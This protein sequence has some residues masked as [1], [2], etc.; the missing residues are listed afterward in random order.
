M[1]WKALE[2]DEFTVPQEVRLTPPDFV[3]DVVSALRDAGTSARKRGRVVVVDD[4]AELERRLEL[5][6]FLRAWAVA[7]PG[8]AVEV[9]EA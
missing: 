6:F 1:S 5:V 2:C 7:H 9:V 3:D 4:D 8:L